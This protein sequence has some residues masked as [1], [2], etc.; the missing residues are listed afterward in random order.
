VYLRSEL[1][2][3]EATR[4]TLALLKMTSK[5][6]TTSLLHR[7]VQREPSVPRRDSRQVAS[8]EPR[9]QRGDENDSSSTLSFQLT[10]PRKGGRKS[11]SAVCSD[12][13]GES[14]G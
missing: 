7:E 11:I 14:K 8:H 13:D 1:C 5:L 3:T 12:V 9:E 6:T 4:G 10:P 2:L